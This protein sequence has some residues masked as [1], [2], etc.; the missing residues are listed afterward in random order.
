MRTAA[1]LLSAAGGTSRCN[2]APPL[3]NRETKRGDPAST[4][5]TAPSRP[6]LRLIPVPRVELAVSNF[7]VTNRLLSTVIRGH[8]SGLLPKTLAPR[9]PPVGISLSLVSCQL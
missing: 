9:A 3:R 2:P 5:V 8:L 1:H 7:K 6:V 4:N